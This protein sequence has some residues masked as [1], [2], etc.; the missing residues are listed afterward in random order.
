LFVDSRVWDQLVALLT[1]WARCVAPDLQLGAHRVAMDRDADL[2]PTGLAQMIAELIERLQLRE[3]T[4]VGNDT[5]GALCQILCANHPELVD[6]L[7]L[8][9]CD[10]FERF[11]PAA[12]RVIEGAGARIPGLIAG[13]D[14]LLR[15]RVL[16]CA[17]LAVA[18]LTMRPLPDELLASWFEPLHD[19]RVRADVRSVLQGISPEHTLAAADRLKTF[20]RPALIA[21]G[22]R[23]RFFPVSDA[24]RLAR[25]L[26]CAHLEL[27]ENARTFVQ[28]DQPRRLAELIAA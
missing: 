11:P 6:R 24:E 23:D 28:I 25:T 19:R 20:D 27:I 4:L 9:N 10:A 21:W 13:L 12:F 3:V 26:P 17:A 22:T 14:F 1:P 18:P 8:T 2:S 5:G 16:R 7:V 15:A